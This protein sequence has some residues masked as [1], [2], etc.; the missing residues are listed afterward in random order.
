MQHDGCGF[1]VRVSSEPEESK[2]PQSPSDAAI[3]G[4]VVITSAI[5]ILAAILTITYMVADSY[6]L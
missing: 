5:L 6:P 2:K 3:F 4:F 1:S